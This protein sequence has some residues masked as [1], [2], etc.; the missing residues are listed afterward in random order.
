MVS[1]L[2]G[3]IAIVICLIEVLY[4]FKSK[5]KAKQD[6]ERKF[7]NLKNTVSLNTFYDSD[8]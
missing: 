2:V 8:I 4:K 7:W 1:S 5:I 3:T 6:V